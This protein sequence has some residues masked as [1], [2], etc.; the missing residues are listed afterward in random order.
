MTMTETKIE[1]HVA[2]KIEPGAILYSSWGYDQTNVDFYMV[3]RTTQASAWIVP[4][5]AR[6]T[7]TGFMSGYSIPLEPCTTERVW[8]RETGLLTE[9]PVVPQ[10]HRI[11]RTTWRSEPEEYLNLTSYSGAYLWDGKRK[12]ASHYA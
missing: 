10:I 12:Y 11:K 8:D 3:T 1:A 9:R 5:S 2:D 6:E 7:E 4:M